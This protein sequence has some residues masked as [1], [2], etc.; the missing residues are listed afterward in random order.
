MNTSIRYHEA[1][2][3]ASKDIKS[4]DIFNGFID[5]DA[6][7]Y[8]MPHL[9]EGIEIDELKDSYAKYKSFFENI[10]NIIKHA[11]R[12]DDVFYRQTQHRFQFHEIAHFG[13]G[14]SKTGK[15][16]SAIGRGFAEKLKLH[17]NWFK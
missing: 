12:E 10:F 4:K 9:L 1:L 16:G 11:K 8:V 5:R 17:T 13:L 2:G 7:F 14:Y 6:E 15:R 3:L